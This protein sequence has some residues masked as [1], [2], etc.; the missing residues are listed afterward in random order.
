[1]PGHLTDKRPCKPAVSTLGLLVRSALRLHA[2]LQ[3]GQPCGGLLAYA[4]VVGI[5]GFGGTAVELLGR[6]HYRGRTPPRGVRAD[7]AATERCSRKYI[8]S[9]RHCPRPA[10]STLP[11]RRSRRSGPRSGPAG[12]P[13]TTPARRSLPDSGRTGR[14]RC[15]RSRRVSPT[16]SPS[17]ACLY[18]PYSRRRGSP[19]SN[20]SR[21][22]NRRP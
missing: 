13:R 18:A 21:T 5:L 16:S 11:R 8:A 12:L 19:P 9:D 15:P 14:L 1:M 17:G 22:E 20:S 2:A 6:H 7:T 4:A 3:L 10:K